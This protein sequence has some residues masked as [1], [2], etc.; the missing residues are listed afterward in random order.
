MRV[1]VKVNIMEMFYVILILL[2]VTRTF[3]EIAFRMGQPS[4][5]GELLAGIA[6][7]VFAST[8]SDIL[9][10]LNDLDENPVFIALVNLGIFFLMLLG[11]VELRAGELAEVSGKSFIIG[12]C[13]L[14]IPLFAGY[15]LAWWFIPESSYKLAQCLFV[16]TA[17]A[18]TAI[19]VSIG[20]LIQ[21]KKLRTPAGKTIVSAAI[22]DDVLS[23]ILLAVLMG[24]IRTGEAPDALQLI[25]LVGQ[26]CLFFLFTFTVAKVI[27]PKVGEIVTSMKTAEFEFTS[28]ILAGLIFSIFAEKLHLH[29]ILGAF[30][31][32]LLFEKRI[33][34]EETYEKVNNYK[35]VYA[36]SI[37]V[38]CFTHN[39]I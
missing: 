31:A 30:T 5:L 4:L 18:I 33:A 1:T 27:V 24:I 13:G 8:Y 35:F 39:G 14:L 36:G 10:F 34:G 6:L 20:I 29:W 16:G 2:F 11:G 15:E 26:V 38:L 37:D 19:P 28:L 32:G 12:T 3:G 17:L 7:G 23:L 9:P 25:M 22:A 21:L